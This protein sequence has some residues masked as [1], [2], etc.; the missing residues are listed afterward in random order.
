MTADFEE[1]LRQVQVKAARRQKIVKMLTELSRQE[2]ELAANEAALRR[3]REKEEYDVV[4]LEQNSL[5]SFF[6]DA[7]GSRA[8]RLDK[9]RAEAYAAAA[10]HDA[11]RRQ[12]ESIVQERKSLE[13]E[14]G[15]LG[16]CEAEYQRLLAEKS[17]WLKANQPGRAAEINRCE[18]RMRQLSAQIRETREAMDAGFAC[19]R[20]MEDIE[21]ELNS[22]S[23]WGTWDLMG[24]GLI[25]D[26][27]KHSHLDQAQ[28]MVNNLQGL[29]RR[30]RTELSDVTL[31]ADIQI[32]IDSF[33]RFADY[34]FDGLFADWA[35][36][37]RIRDSQRQ[38]DATRGQIESIM[39]RLDDMYRSADEELKELRLTYDD[40]VRKA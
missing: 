27:A 36:L 21:K 13:E 6:Y 32:Q 4:R 23:G 19:L 9:E 7:L 22:A 5:V 18:E 11:A 30:F 3:V 28:N 12:L 38:V 24:G 40:L 2:Q 26:L 37:D 15:S 29:L 35:V 8:E 39:H 17:T 31:Y 14:L 20:Q 10:R 33:L 34:F 16:D 1:R 25:S